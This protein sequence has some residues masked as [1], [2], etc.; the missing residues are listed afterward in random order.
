MAVLFKFA[1][2]VPEELMQ[3]VKDA[4]ASHGLTARPFYANP[5]R[6]SMARVYTVSDVGSMEA[7]ESVLKPFRATIEYLEQAPDR[8]PIQARGS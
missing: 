6:P 8:R 5:L 4:L 2:G 1:K 3:A 7:V